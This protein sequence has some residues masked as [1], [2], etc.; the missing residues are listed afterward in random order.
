[1]VVLLAAATWSR[2]G[3]QLPT[4]FGR[5]SQ[6]AGASL[7]GARALHPSRGTTLQQHEQQ[8]Q[9]PG[10][11]GSSHHAGTDTLQQAQRIRAGDAGA[12]AHASKGPATS[13]ELRIATFNVLAPC[14]KRLPSTQLR[15]SDFPSLYRPRNA[16]ILRMLREQ[17]DLDVI[18][19]QE[20]WFHHDVQSM[21]MAALGSG[22][23]VHCL[24]R[25][26][27]RDD[28]VVVFVRNHIQ[29]VGTRRL[30]FDDSGMRVALLLHLRVRGS[31]PTPIAPYLIRGTHAEALDNTNDADIAAVPH[32]PCPAGDG[33]VDLIL[34]NTHFS[35]PHTQQEHEA[36]LQQ[37]R[38]LATSV[39]DFAREQGVGTSV[40]T[41]DFNGNV[42]SRSCAHLISCG[43]ESLFHAVHDRELSV[44]HRTH[45]G[46]DVGVDFV[47]MRSD[48][49]AFTSDAAYALPQLYPD[50]AWPED[51]DLS[52]HRPVVVSLTAHFNQPHAQ[53]QQQ[54]QQT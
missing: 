15:E 22:Y 35:F 1:M 50:Q 28:G 19:L 9:Q 2:C 10:D 17:R 51:F 34:A 27:G 26:K 20:F 41:G 52:D 13:C 49:G 4:R 14:Y 11:G 31:T 6:R 43:Y 25:P 5:L 36:R 37:A 16:A 29:V 47:F 30:H 21:Y 45:K 33:S 12:R 53:S 3:H 18:A 39:Q 32:Q 46:E 7:L 23:H 48:D 44:T 24:Q 8:P 38:V 54:R 40:L 42:N